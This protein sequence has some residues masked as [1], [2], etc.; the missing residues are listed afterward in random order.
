MKKLTLDDQRWPLLVIEFLYMHVWI[1]MR[2]QAKEKKER[3]QEKKKGKQ[4]P[5]GN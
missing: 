3:K 5:V 1:A 4:I 2:N